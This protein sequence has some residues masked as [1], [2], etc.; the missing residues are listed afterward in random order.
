LK[1]SIPPRENTPEYLVMLA[2]TLADAAIES[3]R[4]ADERDRKREERG[5]ETRGESEIAREGAIAQGGGVDYGRE[6]DDHEVAHI[7]Q[8]HM[9]EGARTCG[10][11]GPECRVLEREREE[12]EERTGK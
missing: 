5:V 3:A 6:L 11:W 10:V 7:E 4:W 1:L 2:G 8:S 9:G 12:N